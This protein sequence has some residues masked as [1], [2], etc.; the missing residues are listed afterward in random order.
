MPKLL[1]FL[2]WF[3]SALLSGEAARAQPLEGG[4]PSRIPVLLVALDT[5]PTTEPRFRIVRLG[6]NSARYMILLPDDAAPEV[7][8]EA[9]EA[10]RIVWATGPHPDAPHAMLRVAPSQPARS[11]PRRMLPWG[12]RVLRDLREAR[13]RHVPDVGHVRAVQIWL[14]PLPVG[15]V[16][17][18]P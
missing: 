11:R 14:T 4:A 6:D 16:R 5:L 17:N 1:I 3:G 8:S 13:A 12:D 18:Q 15:A 7:L 10:L 2:S 9:V